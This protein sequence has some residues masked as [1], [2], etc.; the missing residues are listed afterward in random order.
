MIKMGL[1]IDEDEAETVS[2]ERV[3]PTEDIPPLEESSKM[4]EVD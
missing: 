3:A 4:E 2:E 1:G